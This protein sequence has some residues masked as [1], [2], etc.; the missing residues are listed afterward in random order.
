MAPIPYS[1]QNISE[2]DI[3]AVVAVLRSEYLTQ[4]PAIG[5]FEAAFAQRHQVA[6]AVAVANATA[7]LHIACLALG[8]GPGKRVWTSPNSFVASAN[9]ALYCRASVDFVDIDP[10]TRNLS[11]DALADKLERAAAV[12]GLPDLLIPVHFAGLPCDLRE[13]RRLADHYGFRILEDA[14]HATGAS[15]LGVPV[16]SAWADATVFSFH[17]VKILTTAEGGMVTTQDAAIARQLQLLRSH[18]ITRDPAE[19]QLA[20]PGPW[21]Y[22]QQCLGFNHRMTD[23]QAALGLSQLARLDALHASRVALADR[24]DHLLADLPLTL[25]ARQPDR[26]S[27]WHLY[28]VEVDASATDISRAQVFQALRNA[29]IGV[30]VH[31]IPIHLQPFYTAMGFAQGAFPAA[32]RYYQQALSLPLFPAMTVAQ[33]QR[34]VDT[35]RAVLSA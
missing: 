19:L 7:G 25:P 23:L 12:G 20:A 21:Y 6:H 18:G 16:G 2:D 14:S 3:A 5:A 11:V 30:N 4:G 9:C 22:E 34:V 26:V 29:G 17:A 33:Q 27:A 32:E 28:A 10:A 13:M 35:L 1:C 8:I 24:Y 15:Y 31:Y